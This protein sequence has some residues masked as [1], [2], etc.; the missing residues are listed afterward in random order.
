MTQITLITLLLECNSDHK[1]IKICTFLQVTK[2][3][4]I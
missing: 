3:M 4:P 1:G 2:K